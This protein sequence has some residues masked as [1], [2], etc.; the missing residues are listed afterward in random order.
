[1]LLSSSSSSAGSSYETLAFKRKVNDAL[2]DVERILCIEKKPS[3]AGD[4]DH[5]Y[6]DKYELVNSVSNISIIAYMNTLQQLGLDADVL[7]QL[8]SL[9]QLR[10][11]LMH[12]LHVKCWRKKWWMCQ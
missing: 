12:Q 4:V 5:T 10:S 3:I 9:H 2:K 11:V 8:T 7:K 1:M 6:G